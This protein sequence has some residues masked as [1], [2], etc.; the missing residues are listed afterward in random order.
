MVCLCL[1]GVLLLCTVVTL[2][3]LGRHVEVRIG[4]EKGSSG[5]GLGGRRMLGRVLP[6]AGEHLKRLILVCSSSTICGVLHLE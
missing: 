3:A 5:V 2:W 4:S 1:Q 6:P